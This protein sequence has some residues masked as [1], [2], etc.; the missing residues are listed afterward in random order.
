M[1]WQFCARL[2]GV[3]S[4]IWLSGC[5]TPQTQAL[6]KLNSWS[7]PQQVELKAIPFYPQETH[8]CGPASLAMVLNAGGVKITPQ[9]LIPQVYLPQREG[10]L[11]VE[12]LAEQLSADPVLGKVSSKFLYKIR[13]HLEHAPLPADATMPLPELAVSLMAV[14]YL[15]SFAGAAVKPSL[16]EARDFVQPVLAQCRAWRRHVPRQPN[17]DIAYLPDGDKY[18]ADAALIAR[19]IAA[20]GKDDV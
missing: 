10:S 3:F 13:T 8:Q 11:Q 9:E 6:L 2:A 19:F 14:E 12:M 15:A 20:R 4:L 16:Q 7:L 18:R 17:S 1:M 5:A